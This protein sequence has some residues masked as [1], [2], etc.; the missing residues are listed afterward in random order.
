ML[1]VFHVIYWHIIMSTLPANF[2]TKTGDEIA[3]LGFALPEPLQRF[4]VTS[5]KLMNQC[6]EATPS[7]YIVEEMVMGSI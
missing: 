2:G 5:T 1:S 4:V 6:E 7:S 3:G